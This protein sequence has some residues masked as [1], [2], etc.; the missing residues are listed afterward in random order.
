MNLLLWLLA[1]YGVCFVL[2]DSGVFTWP[3]QQLQRVGFM[4]RLLNCYFCTGCWV[5]L[6]LWVWWDWPCAWYHKETAFRVLAGATGAYL[7]SS[8]VTWLEA[9][10]IKLLGSDDAP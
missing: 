6:G 1:V 7:I 5:G 9:A 4:R 3:R 10:A 2:I 8:L